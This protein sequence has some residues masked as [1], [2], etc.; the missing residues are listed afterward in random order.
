[1]KLKTRQCSFITVHRE[2]LSIIK[3]INKTGLL[4]NCKNLLTDQSESVKKTSKNLIKFWLLLVG[5]QCLKLWRWS[6]WYSGFVGWQEQGWTQGV[7]DHQPL[8][9]GGCWDPQLWWTPPPPRPLPPSPCSHWALS[10][11]TWIA[12]VISPYTPHILVFQSYMWGMMLYI[13]YGM[14]S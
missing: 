5:R 13:S 4:S 8:G 9:L 6:F 10:P 14:M 3:W 1:M 12:C 2:Y 7:L 11:H